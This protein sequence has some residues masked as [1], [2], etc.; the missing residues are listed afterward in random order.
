MPASISLAVRAIAS[1]GSQLAQTTAPARCPSE[2]RK[3]ADRNSRTVSSGVR[4]AGALTLV[5]R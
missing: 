1:L 5:T 4:R 3:T 2:A